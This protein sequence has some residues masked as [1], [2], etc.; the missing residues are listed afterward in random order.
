MARRRRRNHHL[1]GAKTLSTRVE[2]LS[3]IHEADGEPYIHK[4]A[5]GVSM[6]LLKDGRVE[7]MRPDGK[8]LWMDT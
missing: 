7:L 8:P 1:E 3:Y 6:L 2:S 4:F 5:A